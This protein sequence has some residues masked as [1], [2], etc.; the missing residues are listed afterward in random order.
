[1]SKQSYHF[2]EGKFI[3]SAFSKEQFPHQRDA[4]GNALREIA[5]VGRSNVGK[6]SLIN[7][8]L[9]KQKLA[10]TSSTP[11]KTQSNNFYLVDHTLFLVD[12]PGY[13]YAKVPITVKEKWTQLIESYLKNRT[14]LQLILF[15][16][17]S[18]HEPTE[19]DLGFLEWAEHHHHRILTIFTK[20]DK[21]SKLAREK[22]KPPYPH[23]PFLYYSIKD[24]RARIGLIHQ[25]NM[26]LD[27]GITE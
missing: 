21:L 3:T 26:M 9:R 19:E 27:N 8:L 12:L 5:I 16:L 11:G 2:S 4:H 18:R 22:K 1:M 23:L 6:S 15:L 10:K 20:A 25:I 7:S 13:G 17:D 14:A 24:A